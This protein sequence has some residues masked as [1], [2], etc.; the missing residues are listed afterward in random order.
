MGEVGSCIQPS[1]QPASFPWP[2][3]KNYRGYFSKY[4][5]LST[6][7]PLFSEFCNVLA[8]FGATPHCFVSQFAHIQD[9]KIFGKRFNVKEL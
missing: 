3:N 1:I 2:C 5:L 8:R 7:H 9:V 6:T 4:E